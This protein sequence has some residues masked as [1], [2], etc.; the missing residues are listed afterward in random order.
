MTKLS[1]KLILL[2][3]V[4]FV[5]RCNGKSIAADNH[6]EETKQGTAFTTKI[7]TAS[8][9]VADTRTR[10]S[11]TKH[12]NVVDSKPNTR[13]SKTTSDEVCTSEK[14]VE[15]AEKIK[16]A[17]NTS[18]DPCEDFY[19]FSCGG[20]KEKHDIPASENEI[21]SFTVLTKEIENAIHDLLK[22]EPKEG[23]SDAL[24]KARKFFAS[25]MDTDT[26]EKLGAEPALDFIKYIGGWSLCKRKE[27]EQGEK[28]WDPYKVLKK[29]QRNFYPA[30]PFF[31]V[32]VT[33][34]HLNSTR[35]L[36]K[37]DQSGLSL[38]REIYTKH[39]EI[40]EDYGEYMIKVAKLL[41]YDCPEVEKEMDEI[42]EFEKRLAK[43]TTPAEAK[44]AGTFR[45]IN[46]KILKSVVPQFPWYSHISGIF[47]ES[48]EISKTEVILATSPMYLYK[49]A[50][51]ITKTPKSMLSKYIVWQMIRDKISFL[52]K[53]FRKARAEFNKKMTGVEDTDPRWRTC[54]SITNDNMGVPIGTLYVEKYF[55]DT[56]KQKTHDMIEEIIKSF[57]SRI[58]EHSWMDNKTRK[59]V[60]EKADALVAKV[61]YASYIK[62]PE[63]LN[64]RFVKLSID[65]DKFFENNL[66]VD[67]WIRYRL[68]NKLRKPVD[69]SKWPMFPQTIN[70]MYQFYENEIVIPAGIL[71]PP[72]FYT[73]D[74]P[75][76]LS[77]GAIGSI[78]G[79]ELTHGFDN[80]GRKFDKNGDIVTE[81]WSSQSLK[82][83]NDKA[84]CIEKQ[85]SKY[86]VQDKYPISGKLT[87]GENIADNG[88]T[89]LSYDAYLDWLKI[90]GPEPKLPGLSYDNNQLFFIGYA[91]EYCANV[92]KKTEY[93]A[94]LSEIHSPSKFRVI[95]TLS[96]FESFSKAF[97]CSKNSRM[98]AKTKCEVW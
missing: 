23:E 20:W 49:V 98:N 68:F 84:R 72:F 82:K 2:A 85:Y 91:Q 83:F 57:K 39:P 21:T 75:R 52:T 13:S 93:I 16:E 80:T 64:K 79:H 3:A 22:E 19:A 14:C 65:E 46:I 7:D 1:R 51:L 10:V 87:L 94:T 5:S 25:C 44:Q 78:I 63:E 37:I 81:W 95:G 71:Q 4:L 54:T 97:K 90:N 27:W 12:K 40:V 77:Y 33:N 35:H 60:D 66:N 41:G 9:S 31:T 8:N 86:K 74:V 36:I 47:P 18:A 11:N 62:K 89:K 30:P 92:R 6:V 56:T 70:A 53:D 24:V 50:N 69:K 45:R 55:S 34:D 67:K 43:M 76:S 61:G 32:E 29:L 59:G 15:V 17:L 38:Q 48:T 73:G 96:N 26:I 42:L 28:D 88:G 58:R